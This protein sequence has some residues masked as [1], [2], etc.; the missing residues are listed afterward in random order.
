[1][2]ET[3]GARPM[4]ESGGDV[5]LVTGGAQGI[6]RAF[7]L[8]L[9]GAGYRTI[10]AD[11]N[12]DKA[13]AVAAAARSAGGKAWALSIDVGDAKSVESAIDSVVAQHGRL[14]VLV[15]NA[16]I[17]ST[18]AVKPFETLSIEEWNR[19]LAIN[20]TGVFLCSKAAVPH[21]R[22]AG[23]GRIVNIA[24]AA[25]RMGRPNYLHYIASKGAVE[26]MT[27]S[28]ARELGPA[29]I[30]VNAIAPGA[31]FTEIPRGTVTET[32]KAAILGAQCVP[33]PGAPDDL[34]STLLHIASPGS[35]FVTGQCFVVD[36]GVIH[37]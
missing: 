3:S 22:A 25:S 21:M 33:R 14:H 28:M 16:A 26:A 29:G 17:F 23:Y 2:N 32:Q 30:T 37:G 9:A 11:L 24:S 13:E 34:V 36:G 27:R 6:G 4:H 20:I 15:N 10:I 1:M 31:I 8:A 19:V 18:L 12:R 35:G 5:A 7:C